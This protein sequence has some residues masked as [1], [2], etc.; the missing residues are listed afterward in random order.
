MAE[1][2]ALLVDSAMDTPKEI[3]D[4]GG[5]FIA[6]LNIIYKNETFLDRVEITPMEVYNRL[7]I[8]IPTTSLPTLPYVENLISDIKTQGYDKIACLTISSGLS[9]TH[10]ALRLILED[11][12]EIENFI[13]DTK[14]IGMGAGIQAAYLKNEIDNGTSFTE[15]KT[16]AEKIAQTTDI[17]FSIPTLEYLKKGG[18]IGLVSSFI[19]TALNLNPIISCNEDGVYYT[20][21]KARGRT[22]SL[23]KILEQIEKVASG[24]QSYDLAISYGMDV[25]EAKKLTVRLK[26]SLPNYRYLYSG[27][28]SPVLGV[29]SGPGIIGIAIIPIS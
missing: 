21:S 2:I 24:L 10:N 12:P 20:V 19:G 28:V 5:I 8:E 9:G 15:L 22:K 16:I 11:H 3:L 17:Y 23:N 29:H 27:D 25:E 6:P 13:V 7:E 26:E 18:R 1:K 4:K 14:N